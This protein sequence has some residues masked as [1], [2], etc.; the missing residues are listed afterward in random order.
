MIQREN[1]TTP[2]TPVPDAAACLACPWRLSNQGKPHPDGW[3]TKKNLARLW[4][5]LRRGEDMSCH[6][7]DP[8]NPISE[9]AQQRGYRP[10]PD[11]S[12]ARECAGSLVLRQREVTL[13]NR[14]HE[15]DTRA[16]R[17]ARPRG[18]TRD[19]IAAV[20]SRA[21]FGGTP[22][23]GAPMARPDLNDLDIGYEVLGDW[24]PEPEQ[25]Q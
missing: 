6:P 7:S 10:A 23:G 21:L 1:S 20:V 12:K 11:H 5:G 18:L 4:A 19:G 2:A 25:G 13:L 8:N 9:N 24:T 17:R 15:G 3:Y 16:Y 14:D 22:L